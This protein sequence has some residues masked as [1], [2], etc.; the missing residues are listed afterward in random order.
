MTMLCR[1]HSFGMPATSTVRAFKN[2]Q[3]NKTAHITCGGISFLTALVLVLNTMIL[4]LTAIQT[5]LLSQSNIQ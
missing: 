4:I 5:T 1:S 3:T 2:I